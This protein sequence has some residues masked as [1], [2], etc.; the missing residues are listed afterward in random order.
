MPVGELLVPV[1]RARPSPPL[2]TRRTDPCRTSVVCYGIHH[3]THI[4]SPLASRWKSCNVCR[5]RAFIARDLMQCE[6]VH[7]FAFNVSDTLRAKCV[8]SLCTV[9]AYRHWRWRRVR[10][11]RNHRPTTTRC[12]RPWVRQY[13]SFFNLY[14]DATWSTVHSFVLIVA[15]TP[16]LP[17]P[18]LLTRDR[19]NRHCAKSPTNASR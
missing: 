16:S 13:I 5:G 2:G 19:T 7:V 3:R 17:L 12:M 1:G 10:R 9:H 18:A 6:G 15:P 4:L 8:V 11:V 14:I